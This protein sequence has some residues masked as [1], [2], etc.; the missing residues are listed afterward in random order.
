MIQPTKSFGP[1]IKEEAT[2]SGRKYHMEVKD[3]QE[4]AFMVFTLFTGLHKIKA[5]IKSLWERCF[6]DGN[7]M[8]IATV[9][10]AQALAFVQRS[11]DRIMSI[12][13]DT[14][15]QQVFLGQDD[16]GNCA[17]SFPGTYC[18]ILSTL[19]DPTDIEAV[20]RFEDSSHSSGNEGEAVSMNDLTFAF[21]ARR[22][23]KL[24]DVDKT[25]WIACCDPLLLQFEHNPRAL[26]NADV[27][28]VLER[29][30][31]LCCTLVEL[32]NLNYVLPTQNPPRVYTEDDRQAESVRKDPILGSLHPVWT[33][34][35]INLTSVFAA[36]IMLD[37]KEI[38]N[39]FPASRSS[40]DD[41]F[42]SYMNLLDLKMQKVPDEKELFPI[43]KEGSPL[44]RG[45]GC[46]GWE[47]K[48]LGI[49]M[50]VFCILPVHN[51]ALNS[52]A[53]TFCSVPVRSADG[54]DFA[55][56]VPWREEFDVDC[57]KSVEFYKGLDP[58]A[59]KYSTEE[60]QRNRLFKFV[61]IWTGP[62]YLVDNYPI[63]TTSRE[64]F[65][66]TLTEL[67]GIEILNVNKHGIGA[68]AHLYNASRQLG[69]GNLRWPAMDRIIDLHKVALFAGDLPTTP[70]AMLKSFSHRYWGPKG[71]MSRKEKT[72]RMNRAITLMKPSAMTQAYN[73]HWDTTGRI[74]FWYTLESNA[75]AA[76]AEKKAGKKKPVSPSPS[77][78]ESIPVI[79]E[80]LAKQLQDVRVDYIEVDRVGEDFSK[81]LHKH[82]REIFLKQG[83][84]VIPDEA[85]DRWSDIDFVSESFEQEAQLHE[86]MS[87]C[88]GNPSKLPVQD[89]D[90]L[91]DSINCLASSL[92]ATGIG[93]CQDPTDGE[94]VN[95][96]TS[97]TRFRIR[98]SDDL[99]DMRRLVLV[100]HC[101][102]C[103]R[104]HYF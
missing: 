11:E 46:D 59:L 93:G 63:F 79:E 61:F 83:N 99:P 41:M 17:W 57:K 45:A 37:I 77:F 21:S 47:D 84:R 64:A 65:M 34:K 81:S 90:Y 18:R 53:E 76:A 51:T 27:E 29:D 38:C 39:A 69:L 23:S 88:G 30:R 91:Q 78:I 92:R 82:A 25:P 58:L 96:P 52:R 67:A 5:E 66:Q 75:L 71:R 3:S 40:Y 98:G 8:I 20:L 87:K 55:I 13:E 72:R 102:C 6:K 85:D 62:F 44:A 35:E 43:C 50:K 49:L 14:K 28:K 80:Y 12:L 22:L 68:M 32:S 24:T 48:V 15:F 73:E 95:M 101:S 26:L 4:N 97:L 94:A 89:C 56:N 10:T 100:S 16:Q 103:H 70:A 7:D 19:R 74:P 54:I 1:S 31:G 86:A 2:T 33:R 42:D 60:Y 9:I 104:K 36:E